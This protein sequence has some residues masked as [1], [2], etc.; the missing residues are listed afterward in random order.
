MTPE[1]CPNCGA[2]LRPRAKSCPECG[3]DETTG[4]SDDAKQ[5]S[6]GLPDDSFDYDDFV[7]REFG[8]KKRRGVR[9]MKPLWRMVAAA[10]VILFLYSLW[11]GWF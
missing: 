10:L 4:W 5:Q 1:T 6:L 11:R 2:A 8:G 9:G 7:E 3:A